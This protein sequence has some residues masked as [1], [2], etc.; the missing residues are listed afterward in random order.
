MRQVL[1]RV[2]IEGILVALGVV[3]GKTI[4]WFIIALCTAVLIVDGI[5]RVGG[6]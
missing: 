3:L 2:A 1:V 6:L 5:Y 4:A